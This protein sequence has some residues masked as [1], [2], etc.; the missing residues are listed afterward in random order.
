MRLDLLFE[1]VNKYSL[2]CCSAISV[3][4]LYGKGRNAVP[5]MHTQVYV[6]SPLTS[7]RTARRASGS[8]PR[9][10]SLSCLAPHGLTG[11]TCTNDATLLLT[12]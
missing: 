5:L 9:S 7:K 8:G 2:A 6:F 3:S 11:G 1:I 4:D 10:A 12:W